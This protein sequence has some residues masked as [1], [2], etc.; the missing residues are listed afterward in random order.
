VRCVGNAEAQFLVTQKIAGCQSSTGDHVNAFKTLARGI[1][2]LKAARTRELSRALSVEK[3][4]AKLR[5]GS[6]RIQQLELESKNNSNALAQAL[7]EIERQ[8]HVILDLHREN[9]SSQKL[10]SARESR[11]N[12][13][14]QDLLRKRVPELSPTELRICE[15]LALSIPTKEIALLLSTSTRTIEWHRS[16]IRKKIKLSRKENLALAL[17]KLAK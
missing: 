4:F 15:M 10:G 5:R 14:A 8:R 12:S 17:L 11:S 16:A 13:T 7:K 9:P 1:H 6:G 2:Q 3:E